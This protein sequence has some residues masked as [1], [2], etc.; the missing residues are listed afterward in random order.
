VEEKEKE[1]ATD[2][3]RLGPAALIWGGPIFSWAMW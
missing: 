2:R 1:K 3:R